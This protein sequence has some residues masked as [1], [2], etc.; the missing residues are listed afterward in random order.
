[1]C[2]LIIPVNMPDNP[3]ILMSQLTSSCDPSSLGLIIIVLEPFKIPWVNSACIF[4]FGYIVIFCMHFESLNAITISLV[5]T[6]SSLEIIFVS[7]V[8]FQNSGSLSRSDI[9]SQTLSTEEM[10]SICT[11][12]NALRLW[13]SF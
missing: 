4:S 3:D 10:M 5:I 7:F 6:L 8:P 9:M 1:M 2:F 12:M 13:Y 11:S